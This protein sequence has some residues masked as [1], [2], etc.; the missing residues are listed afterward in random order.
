M[1]PAE[2]AAKHKEYMRAYQRALKRL[3]N[4]HRGEFGALLN[5]ERAKAV[6]S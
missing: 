4:A 3:R 1:T 6:A 2:K 5:E